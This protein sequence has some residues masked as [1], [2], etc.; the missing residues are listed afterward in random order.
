M[1]Y[2]LKETLFKNVCF[3]TFKK[4]SVNLIFT[5]MLTILAKANHVYFFGVTVT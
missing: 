2:T 3:S 5:Q 4:Q 1:L